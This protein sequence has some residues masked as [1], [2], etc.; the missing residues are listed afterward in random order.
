[1]N[2]IPPGQ[3]FSIVQLP[4]LQQGLAVYRMTRRLLSLSNIVQRANS[5]VSERKDE[6]ADSFFSQVL[7]FDLIHRCFSSLFI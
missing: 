6:P 2:S 3:V 4:L 7:C 1:M 5:T